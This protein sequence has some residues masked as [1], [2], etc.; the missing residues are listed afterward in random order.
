MGEGIIV[1]VLGSRAIVDFNHPLAG[2]SVHYVYTIEDIIE[3]PLQ[4]INGLIH[5]YAHIN[6]EVSL[7]D[8]IAT[9]TLPPG[10]VFNRRWMIWRSEIIREAFDAIPE[11]REIVLKE[12][13]LRPVERS[14]GEGEEGEKGDEGEVAKGEA[15]GVSD[16]IDE[17]V[18]NDSGEE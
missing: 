11:L 15:T 16:G 9:I 6:C 4:K 1:D 5:L 8:G 7:D 12:V 14:V 2:K 18:M 17:G 10:I 13:F 3:D